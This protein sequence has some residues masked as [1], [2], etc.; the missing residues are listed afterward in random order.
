MD[1]RS[2]ECLCPIIKAGPTQA[3]DPDTGILY[4]IGKTTGRKS[5][6]NLITINK[7]TGKVDQV[8][9]TDRVLPRVTPG[10]LGIS[11]QTLTFLP[12]GKMLAAVKSDGP[13]P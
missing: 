5:T 10:P 4:G 11:A 9:K 13:H 2:P 12:N 8:I 7:E 6:Q 3:I 1:D